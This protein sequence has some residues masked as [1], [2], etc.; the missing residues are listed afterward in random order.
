MLKKNKLRYLLLYLKNHRKTLLFFLAFAAILLAVYGLYG[1]AWGA[2]G[3]AL[4]LGTA[5]AAVFAVFDFGRY[6]GRIYSL[7]KLVG[8]FPLGRLPAPRGSVE[9]TYNA[10]VTA[11]EDERMRLVAKLEETQRDAQEYYTL[12]AH[13]I[14]TPIAAMRLQ[15]QQDEMPPAALLEQELFKV[16][17][18]VGMVLEYQRLAGQSADLLL[19]EYRLES[20]V[21]QAAKNMAPLFIYQKL[22]LHLGQIEGTIVT[23]LKWFVFVLEQILSNSLKYTHK[24]QVTIQSGPNNT[25]LIQDTGIGIPPEDLPRVFER[26]YTGRIGR[27]QLR[28]TGIGLYLCRNILKRLGFG[29]SIASQ[30]GKGTTVTLHLQ[31]AQLLQD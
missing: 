2:A 24:G 14:K 10:M 1:Y 16:E 20:L 4:L 28:A 22:T 5:A 26:G 8:R 12:W 27:Q 30:V 7:E 31:Q 18:Y 11:Q 6:M 23:D 9:E 15:L 25:L 21:K 13:Q 3:Y 29:I 19:E 17:Q